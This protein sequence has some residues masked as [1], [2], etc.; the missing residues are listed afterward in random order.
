[1]ELEF[2]KSQKIT[3]LSVNATQMLGEQSALLGGERIENQIVFSD[4]D[5][6]VLAQNVQMFG[7]IAHAVSNI[8][9]VVLAWVN[10]IQS[11][12]KNEI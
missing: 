12:I 3:N 8:W 9:N 2:Q 4:N 10:D 5:H 1:M 7:T 11:Q 6:D